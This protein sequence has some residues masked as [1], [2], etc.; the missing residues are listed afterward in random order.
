MGLMFVVF[1]FSYSSNGGFESISVKGIYTKENIITNTTPTTGFE[2]TEVT[3]T[4]KDG[5]KDTYFEVA[6]IENTN[7]IKGTNLEIR[8]TEGFQSGKRIYFKNREGS[9]INEIKFSLRGNLIFDWSHNSKTPNLAIGYRG[10]EG[11]KEISNYVSINLKDIEPIDSLK[12]VVKK[13][14]DLGRGIAGNPLNTKSTGHPAVIKVIGQKNAKIKIFIP[15]KVKIENSLRDSIDVLLH[16]ASNESSYDANTFVSHAQL[17]NMVYG[18]GNQELGETPDIEI[19]G[20]CDSDK[21][22][23]G[24]YTGSFV[25]RVGYD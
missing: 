10:N 14:M 11:K 13:D 7:F 6:N 16:F 18:K 23:R 20:Q 25:V 21:K 12:V 8:V 15:K 5:D 9:L 22:S 3:I 1:S 4:K 19:H 17:T 24:K 2:I